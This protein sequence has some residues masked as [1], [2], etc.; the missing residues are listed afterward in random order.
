MAREL[1]PTSTTLADRPVPPGKLT[2]E[3]FLDWA[4]EDTFAEWVDGEVVWMSPVSKE[5]D[6]LRVFLLTLIESIVQVH[7]L[8]EVH[9]EPFQMKT[10]PTLPGRSPDI[11][12]ISSERVSRIRKTYLEG[13][14]DVV[15][16]IVSPESRQR[17]CVDK[18]GEYEQG[19]VRE[20]WLLDQ[21]LGQARFHALDDDGRYQLLP[22]DE[23]GVFQSRVLPDVRLKIEWLWQGPRPTVLDILREWGMI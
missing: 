10:G 2:Y 11:L 8:G 15:I 13:P 19:G 1:K 21:P 7:G 9:G 3:Q 22:I 23:D 5:H 16:E 18:L 6:S 12:F 4:D 17:D 20:Y 14:A